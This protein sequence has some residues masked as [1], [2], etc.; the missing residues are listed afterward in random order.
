MLAQYQRWIYENRRRPSVESVR[1]WIIMEP[2]HQA[3]A[4]ETVYGFQEQ[5]INALGYCKICV[6]I[7]G[8]NNVTYLKIWINEKDGRL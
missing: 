2:E 7:I 3:M 5:A 4:N 6:K 1:E 8:S